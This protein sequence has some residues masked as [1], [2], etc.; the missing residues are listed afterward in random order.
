[1]LPRKQ[2]CMR[3]DV[4]ALTS[5]QTKAKDIVFARKQ[6]WRPGP[7]FVRECQHL[8]SI[9]SSLCRTI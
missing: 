4:K 5:F 3:Q 6:M 2:K 9:Q 8:A 1:M 7:P